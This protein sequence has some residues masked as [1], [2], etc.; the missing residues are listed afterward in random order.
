MSVLDRDVLGL[1]D[2]VTDARHRN[3]G[4]GT[5][6]LVEMLRHAKASG[7][8]HA[9]LQVVQSNAAAIHLYEKLG[10]RKRYAYWYRIAAS[11]VY[12]G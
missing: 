5:K 6:L 4:Y 10:F 7:A 9:T 12:N 1:F 2:I 8:D 11:M 3:K